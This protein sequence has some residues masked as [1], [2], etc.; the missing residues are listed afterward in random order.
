MKS[1]KSPAAPFK[2]ALWKIGLGALGLFGPG[3]LWA[4]REWRFTAIL[5]SFVS[6]CFLLSVVS[7]PE[8]EN[9]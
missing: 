5:I 1:Q 9:S 7:P 6:L 3:L 8:K 2:P 4:D